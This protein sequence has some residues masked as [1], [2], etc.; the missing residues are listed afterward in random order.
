MGEFAAYIWAAYGTAFVVMTGLLVATIVRLRR[1]QTRL[2]T[3][4]E[5]TEQLRRGG[6]ASGVPSGADAP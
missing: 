5:R 6:S 1:A 4:E 2:Q 3:L